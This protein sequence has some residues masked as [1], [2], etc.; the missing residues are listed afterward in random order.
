M[1]KRI[2]VAEHSE[3]LAE[4]M[5]VVLEGEGYEVASFVERR[6]R[7][8]QQP[9][10]LN[11]V[12]SFS[13]DLCIVDLLPTAE[14]INDSF[15]DQLR[16]DARSAR[17]PV[18]AVTTSENVAERSLASYNVRGTLTKPFDLEEVLEEVRRALG[19]PVI[20]PP[21]SSDCPDRDI[22]CEAHRILA[23]RSREALFRWVQRLQ[24]EPFFKG[25]QDL[26]LPGYLDNMPVLVEAVTA[27]LAYRSAEDLFSRTPE[28]M[29][30][31]KRHAE[32]RKGQGIPL[33]AI[34]NEYALLRDEIGQLLA[35]Y[36]PRDL[37][38]NDVLE[39]EREVNLTLDRIISATIPSYGNAGG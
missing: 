38:T 14:S 4:L 8:D 25:R 24:T 31:T 27:A 39:M 17:I 1:Q 35:R 23:E 5:T 18:L 16:T 19:E 37:P 15:L 33:E 34:V 30:R 9:D 36:L 22:F 6:T 12:A 32:T 3:D 26:K 11:R 7:A 20:A 29:E 21:A 10:F 2:L 13:P 28:V